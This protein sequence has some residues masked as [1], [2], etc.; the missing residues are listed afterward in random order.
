M[1]ETVTPDRLL[2][3]RIDAHLRATIAANLLT[4][5]HAPL[6][7]GKTTALR[8]ALDGRSDLAWM[9]A[10]PWHR[11]AFA[12]PLVAAIRAVRP[13]FGRV[14][15]G[16]VA[17]G[18]TAE[19]LAATFTGE[20]THLDDPLLLLIDD[21]HV[22]AEDARFAAFL[23]RVLRDPPG[24]LR[25]VLCG[26]ALPE[27][28]LGDLFAQRR[29][30][31]VDGEIF[32]FDH[33]EIDAL[34]QALGRPLDA[35]RVRELVTIT[36]GWAAGIVLALADPAYSGGAT[37]AVTAAYLSEELLA[38]L[39]A[40]LVTFLEQT[41]VFE[42]LDLRVLQGDP[43]FAGAAQRIAALRRGGALLSE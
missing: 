41:S 35:E 29:A 9:D 26:R 34:A 10:K 39:P 32:V 24:Q 20:L 33:A 38:A 21:A 8:T 3:P 11:A 6:G 23:S 31:R 22:F 13:G 30:A 28:P 36:S 19:H 7:A 4:L 42:T 2:R 12:E 17:A 16:G 5:V 15:L 27:L 37:R 40:D 25:I 1:K 18:A 14:T 43:A